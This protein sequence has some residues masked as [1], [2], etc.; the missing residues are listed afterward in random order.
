MQFYSHAPYARSVLAAFSIVLFSGLAPGQGCD[1]TV[2]ESPPKI[3]KRKAP[4]NHQGTFTLNDDA[5]IEVDI[6][7]TSYLGFIGGIWQDRDESVEGKSAK[8]YKFKV[9]QNGAPA[10]DWEGELIG[11]MTIQATVQA[12]VS[13]FSGG[14][15]VVYGKLS[16][17]SQTLSVS[18]T[19]HDA[20]AV[21]N[22]QS[23]GITV[24]L[25][26]GISADGPSAGASIS[27][28]PA[29]PSGGPKTRLV[30]ID[31][32]GTGSSRNCDLTLFSGAALELDVDAFG[33][34]RSPSATGTVSE[35]NWDDTNV[36]AF[37]PGTDDEIF[38]W[39]W[40]TDG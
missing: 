20:V 19:D 1:I 17:V 6:T 7:V 15:S 10:V 35:N 37:C 38:A 8:L 40:E 36:K 4:M 3:S 2:S 33:L 26:A 18:A 29:R 5:T 30:C 24:G 13:V 9:D 28:R 34:A 27:V 32:Q 25:S 22:L 23:G 16:A 39:Y 11:T 31:K 21:S 14:Q 12:N